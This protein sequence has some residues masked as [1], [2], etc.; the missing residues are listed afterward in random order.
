MFRRFRSVE[1]PRTISVRVHTCAPT[2]SMANPHTVPGMGFLKG[3]P[4]AKPNGLDRCA[5]RTRCGEVELKITLTP[6]FL[7]KPLRE[8][9]VE[10]FLKVH[11]KRAAA[12]VSWDEIAC[13]KIDGYTVDNDALETGPC[14]SILHSEDMSVE[15]LAGVPETLFDALLAVARE[16]GAVTEGNYRDPPPAR[17]TMQLLR[18]AQA[19]ADAEQLDADMARRSSNAFEAISGGAA[20]VSGA[21]V[22]AMLL[23]DAYVC[24]LCFP[25]NSPHTAVLGDKVRRMAVAR[26]GE[27][28]VSEIEFS[29]FF[30]ALS[31]CACAP[32]AMAEELPEDRPAAYSQE[33]GDAGNFLQQLLDDDN[34]SARRVA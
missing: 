19:A 6:K 20:A 2:A 3:N 26:A 14:G 30:S 22:R 25:Q 18:L 10:P 27:A 24:G 34:V 11:N 23:G 16:T 32:A 4:A 33:S 31:A 15:L 8:A 29:R 1:T 9:L 13:V 21:K 5:C 28:S 7:L 17:M 12:A